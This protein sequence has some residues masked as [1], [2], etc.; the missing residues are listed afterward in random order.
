[1]WRDQA[2]GEKWQAVRRL[3][4]VVTGALEVDRRDK[5]I[6]SSLEAAPTVYVQDPAYVE[7]LNGLDLA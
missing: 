2:L 6:G 1:M 4:R 7:V 3:R 5:R